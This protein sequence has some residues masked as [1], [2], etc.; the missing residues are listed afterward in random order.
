VLSVDASSSC[1]PAGDSP[2]GVT[3]SVDSGG[4]GGGGG[5]AATCC[6]GWDTYWASAL[7]AMDVMPITSRCAIHCFASDAQ[8]TAANRCRTLYSAMS[9]LYSVLGIVKPCNINVC[10]VST[11]SRWQRWLLHAA[12]MLIWHTCS[13]CNITW[14]QKS[15]TKLLTLTVT[16]WNVFMRESNYCFQRV[17]A[18]AILS[19][20]PS[21]GCISQ[22]WHKLG[23]PNFHHRLPGRL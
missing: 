7:T 20:H 4:G 1:P 2:G 21:H 18:I 8:S 22:K 11:H 10:H 9:L 6:R 23:L 17:L 12:L 19:V 15:S 14:T 13:A 5:A 3:S 16:R